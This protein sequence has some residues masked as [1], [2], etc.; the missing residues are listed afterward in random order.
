MIAFISTFTITGDEKEFKRLMAAHERYLRTQPG[1]G[2]F[3]LR[4]AE[5]NPA[6]FTNIIEWEDA[7][8]HHRLT[9]TREFQEQ[10]TRILRSSIVTCSGVS[11]SAQLEQVAV[12]EAD[13]STSA[14]PIRSRN[15]LRPEPVSGSAH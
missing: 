9:E 13:L 12:D 4:P 14:R 3:E 10:V 1:F 11:A 5:V 2:G 8:S 7:D 6:E 15:K